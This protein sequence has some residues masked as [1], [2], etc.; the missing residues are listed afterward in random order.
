M[1]I[2]NAVLELQQN[3]KSSETKESTSCWSVQ[4]LEIVLCIH[5][6]FFKI[7]FIT[8]KRIKRKGGDIWLRGGS[9]SPSFVGKILQETVS[10]S[11][12]LRLQPPV[13]TNWWEKVVFR[14]CISFIFSLLDLLMHDQVWH[15]VPF[16]WWIWPTWMCLSRDPRMLDLNT[17]TLYTVPR[18]TN[19]RKVPG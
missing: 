15:F 6:V 16:S 14:G 3:L 12:I 19:Q 8:C 17:C 18:P 7:L 5:R 9:C 13:R 1:S 11:A 2:S 10:F 4:C